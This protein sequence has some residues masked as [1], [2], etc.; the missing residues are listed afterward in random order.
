MNVTD[1]PRVVTAVNSSGAWFESDGPGNSDFLMYAFIRKDRPGGEAWIP[2]VGDK[3]VL[4]L[5][6]IRGGRILYAFP[7]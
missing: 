3:A 5:M 7:A 2:Q 4:R 6:P 1:R